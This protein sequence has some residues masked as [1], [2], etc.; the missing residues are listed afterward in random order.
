MKVVFTFLLVASSMASFTVV[1]AADPYDNQTRI[2]QM[3]IDQ[4]M[5]QVQQDMKFQNEAAVNSMHRGS[6]RTFAPTLPGYT[7]MP[8]GG[9]RGQNKEQVDRF[10][11]GL[12]DPDT[13]TG[14]YAHPTEDRLYHYGLLCIEVG[15]VSEGVR[16]LTEH[17][18]L[19]AQ[20]ALE[21]TNVDE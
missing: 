17:T 14:I 8:G 5:D 3:E 20:A 15:F 4:R 13:G 11:E 7:S 6:Q 12:G 2:R 9:M 10:L 21:Q 1:M 19:H 18:R 16:A